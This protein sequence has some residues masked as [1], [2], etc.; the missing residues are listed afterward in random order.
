MKNKFGLLD[1]DLDAILSLLSDHAAVESA[2]IFGSRAKGNFRNGSDVDIALKG[3][4]L[5]FDTI[6]KI[7]Y[8]LNEETNMPYKF[9]VLN[10]HSIKEPE[11]LMHI[12]RVGIEIYCRSK[13]LG[14]RELGQNY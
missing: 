13:Q 12:D 4:N 5:D 14:L 2:Y 10:Y 11:L 8:F 6:S 1:T 3:K 7:S 9:D